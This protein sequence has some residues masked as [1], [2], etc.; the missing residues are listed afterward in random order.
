MSNNQGPKQIKSL[1]LRLLWL[2]WKERK[3]IQ[4]DCG[5]WFS[6][7]FEEEEWLS[8]F[9]R[10]TQVVMKTLANSMTKEKES[11]GKTYERLM[12]RTR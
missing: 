1:V 3:W 5:R 6:V 8:K 11:P 10:K 2:R 7:S 4:A 12:F 9:P